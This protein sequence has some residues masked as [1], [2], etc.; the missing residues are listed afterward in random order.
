MVLGRRDEVVTNSASG[1]VDEAAN[2]LQVDRG[3][4]EGNQ[5][6][7]KSDFTS[8]TNGWMGPIGEISVPPPENFLLKYRNHASCGFKSVNRVVPMTLTR[9]CQRKY[10][11][12]SRVRSPASTRSP[13][14][15]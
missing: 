6:W 3:Q 13:Y 12:D 4:T 14:L 5:P 7:T 8:L 9:K 1:N 11:V 15:V 2:S 10:T